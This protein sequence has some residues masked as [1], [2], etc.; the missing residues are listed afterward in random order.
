MK[1]LLPAIA[2]V[3]AAGPAAPADNYPVRPVRFIVA[4]AAGGNVDMVARLVGHKLTESMGRPFVVDNRGGA[5]GV[6]AEE[7]TTRSPAD[8]YTLLLVSISHVVNPNLGTKLQYDPLRDLASISQVT[9]VPNVLVVHI[10]VPARS[11][12]ELIA[13]AK[14]KPGQLNYASS[15]GTT[16]FLG[17]ELFK[18]MA[19]VDIVSVNYKSGGL[20]VPDLEAGRVQ[21]A[22]SVMT[23][24][25][26]T[27]KS[28]RIRML[29]VTSPKRS[30]ALPE[31]PAMAEFLPGYESTGWQGV[32][33]PAGTPRA[34]IVRLAGE[35]ANAM[36]SAD[37]R[38]KLQSMGADP[39]GS[40]PEEFTAFRKAELTRVRALMAKAGI[41]A[42]N[43][44]ERDR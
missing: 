27:A 1:S 15:H 8:G 30:P 35:I 44:Q 6:I 41:K 33:A 9:S 26:N 20:A 24:A 7:I 29:A 42:E 16:L 10:S 17:G 3:A 12:P 5:G 43:Q 38:G 2:A 25:I 11:V 23:T 32:L 4:T 31:L 39:I 37:L 21:M 14:S 36:R 40:T 34:L 18:A 19:G 13:L 22:F 28:G